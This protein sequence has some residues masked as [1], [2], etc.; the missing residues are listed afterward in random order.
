MRKSITENQIGAREEEKTE[1][2]IKFFLAVINYI[3]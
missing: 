2:K 3:I 1:L